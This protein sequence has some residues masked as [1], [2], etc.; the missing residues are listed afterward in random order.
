MPIFKYKKWN[1]LLQMNIIFREDQ[2]EKATNE[3]IVND[4]ILDPAGMINF[5]DLNKRL[6]MLI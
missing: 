6:S 4:T 1:N 5:Y 2:N 3:D